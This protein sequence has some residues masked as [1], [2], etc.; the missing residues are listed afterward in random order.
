LVFG[1]WSGGALV[2]WPWR[3]SCWRWRQA[4]AVGRAASEIALY[5]GSAGTPP[6][7]QGWAYLSYGGGATVGQTGGATTVDTTAGNAASAGYFASAAGFAGSIAA[8]PKLDRAHGYTITF[9]AQVE[10]EAHAASDDDGDGI[11]DRAGFSVIVLSSDLRGI[12][13]GFWAE[14]IWAQEGGS[15]DKLFTQAEGAAF[16]TRRARARFD[17]AYVA[18]STAMAAPPKQVFLP[19]VKRLRK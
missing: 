19:S 8:V 1:P 10:Q 3:C 17:L 11:D 2:S 15:G 7:A 13:L 18:A 4:S 5:D 14:R 12:E 9:R 16:D 6:D